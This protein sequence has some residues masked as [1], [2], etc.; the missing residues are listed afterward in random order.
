MDLDLCARTSPQRKLLRLSAET[1][2]RGFKL[3]F[4]TK[5]GRGDILRTVYFSSGIERKSVSIFAA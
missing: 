5:K 4:R 1:M 2:V 3:L